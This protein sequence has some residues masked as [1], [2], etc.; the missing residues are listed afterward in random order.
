[1]LVRCPVC[2]SFSL[3]CSSQIEPYEEGDGSCGVCGFGYVTIQGRLSR[4]DL[5][6]RRVNNKLKPLSIKKYENDFEP[7]EFSGRTFCERNEDG[8]MRV[9]K[10]EFK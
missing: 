10:E 7:W 8:T 2:V 3:G 4:E 6:E 5:N 9:L 1:M